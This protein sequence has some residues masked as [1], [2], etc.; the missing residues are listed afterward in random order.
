[1]SGTGVRERRVTAGALVGPTRAS[2]AHCCALRRA[3]PALPPDAATRVRCR[4]R[5]GAAA[6][7]SSAACRTAAACPRFSPPR[8]SRTRLSCATASPRRL[9]RASSSRGGSTGGSTRLAVT[10]QWVRLGMVAARRRGR[11]SS[12]C[13]SRAAGVRRRGTDVCGMRGAR[14]LLRGR[15]TGGAA[16]LFGGSGGRSGHGGRQRSVR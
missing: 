1:M 7:G 14:L 2:A 9:T 4:L 12:V 5:A 8:R 11:G 13:A 3:A 10:A 15:G 16:P 6:T